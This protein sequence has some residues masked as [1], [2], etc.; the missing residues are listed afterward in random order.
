MAPLCSV[1]EPMIHSGVAEA[2][3][4]EVH[5]VLCAIAFYHI[6][7]ATTATNVAPKTRIRIKPYVC[8]DN[9]LSGRVYS[10]GAGI[11]VFS[12]APMS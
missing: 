9:S 10:I 11:Y 12:L 1:L 6:L 2:G 5:A 3:L 7:H 8:R 4:Q